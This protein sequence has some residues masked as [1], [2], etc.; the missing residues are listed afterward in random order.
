MRLKGVYPAHKKD[1]APYFRAS[2]TYRHKHISLGSFND[3]ETAHLAYLEGVNLLTDPDISLLQYSENALLSYE[4][5]V[6]LLNFRDNGIYFGTPIYMGKRL[7]YYHLAPAKILKFD[8]DDLFYLSSHKIMCRGNHYFV[9]DYGMQINLASRYGIKNYAVEGRDFRFLNG[10][11]TDFRRE[12]LEILNAYHGVRLTRQKNGQYVYTVRIHIR[13]DYL[14][15]QY[16]SEEEAAVAYNKAIDILH[17]NGVRKNYTPNYIE[18]MSPSR[19][20]DIYTAL[21][22]SSRIINY[23]PSTSPSNR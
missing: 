4:K 12:N 19:Y 8:L 18:G 9:A 2:L 22:I 20:A 17:K 23:R 10:D 21:K 5:W 13:G 14:V 1:G 7:F 6:C 16:R 3:P 15:G 11:S